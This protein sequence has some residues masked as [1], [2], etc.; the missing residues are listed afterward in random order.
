MVWNTRLLLHSDGSARTICRT[1]SATI[2]HNIPCYSARHT[3]SC[4]ARLTFAISR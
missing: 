3:V 1:L 4:I 2:V